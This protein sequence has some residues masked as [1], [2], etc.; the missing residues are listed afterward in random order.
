MTIQAV[1]FDIGGILEVVPGGGDPTRYFT[2]LIDH[3]NERLHMPLGELRIQLTQMNEQ[4]AHM[5]KDPGLGTCTEQEWHEAL[6][7]AA[8]MSPAQLDV[9]LR[10]YWNV[11][12]GTPNEEMMVFFKSLR[13]R[14][15]TA[16]LS[17]SGVGARRE[18]QQRYHFSDMTDLIIYSHE[19]GVEKP[20]QRIYTIAC[21]RLGMQP[22]EI[23]FLDDAILNVAAALEYGIHAILYQNNAQAIMDI[24]DAVSC[25][26]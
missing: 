5:G 16:L 20:D 21:E 24:E 17:N 6:A 18:E 8:G 1:V 10:D 23:V 15:R 22:E 7:N 14:Y 4:L 25:R 3:W 11:Y 13:P 26:C 2:E 12:L 9:F 19:E